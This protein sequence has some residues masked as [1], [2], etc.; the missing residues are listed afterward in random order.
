MSLLDPSL[1]LNRLVKGGAVKE[2]EEFLMPPSLLRGHSLFQ[3]KQARP[4][5]GGTGLG[6]WGH[7][8]SR[9]S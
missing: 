6:N 1:P 2:G 7:L 8:R 4:A 9:E 3:E 5:C